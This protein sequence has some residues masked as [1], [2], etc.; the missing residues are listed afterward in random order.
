RRIHL[1]HGRQ[2]E[3]EFDRAQQTGLIVLRIHDSMPASVRTGDIAG[4]PIATHMIPAGLRVVFDA[5]NTRLLP[6]LAV[7]D[8]FQDAA[9]CKVMIGH[10]RRRRLE[11]CAGAA[12]VVVWQA[13]DAQ[14]WKSSLFFEALQFSNELAGP[15]HIGNIQSPSYRIGDQIWAQGFDRR[16]ATDFDCTGLLREV[17]VII[18]EFWRPRFTSVFPTRF[19]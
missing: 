4:R 3:N 15:K 14:V 8:R 19:G 10:H 1:V 16:P 7:T 2:A 9:K 13:N 12:G 5:K 18:E 6:E 11:T 17:L